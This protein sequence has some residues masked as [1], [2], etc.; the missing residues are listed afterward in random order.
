MHF[1]KQKSEAAHGLCAA[2]ELRPLLAIY[3]HAPLA[4]KSGRVS[5]MLTV[6]TEQQCSGLVVFISRL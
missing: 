1:P 4:R 6:G 3:H 2:L 5:K